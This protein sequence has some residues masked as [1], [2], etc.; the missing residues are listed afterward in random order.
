MIYILINYNFIKR[1]QV[2]II[3]IFVQYLL[4]IAI[5]FDKIYNLIDLFLLLR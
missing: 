3:T 4:I 5:P 2:M 1:I